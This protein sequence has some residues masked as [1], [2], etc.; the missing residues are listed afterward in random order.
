MASD[1]ACVARR[2]AGGRGGERDVRM[3]WAVVDTEMGHGEALL[4]RSVE[5]R[6]VSGGPPVLTQRAVRLAW[7]WGR[8]SP[9]ERGEQPR[10]IDQAGGGAVA[11]EGDGSSRMPCAAVC[12]HAAS[13][14]ELGIVT[15]LMSAAM[16]PLSERR[17]NWRHPRPQASG[18]CAASGAAGWRAETRVCGT[19]RPQ[20]I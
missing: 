16:T 1:T 3:F 4:S 7:R 6:S 9:L 17:V 15:F 2:M 5:H 10:R 12:A 8:A 13:D 14:V 20:A 18:A 11:C 19:G